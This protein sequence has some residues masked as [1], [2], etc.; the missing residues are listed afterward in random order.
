MMKKIGINQLSVFLS[1]FFFLYPRSLPKLG[2]E[3]IFD[4]VFAMAAGKVLFLKKPFSTSSASPCMKSFLIMNQKFF[5][6]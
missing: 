4:L 3:F 5:V 2:I 6:D 1:L